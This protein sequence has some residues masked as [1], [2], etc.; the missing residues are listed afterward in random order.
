MQLELTH[1]SDWYKGVAEMVIVLLKLENRAGVAQVQACTHYALG[2][3][4]TRQAI[5][6]A[7]YYKA[8]NRFSV[9]TIIWH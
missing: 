4:W 3:S 8:Y 1:Q 5:N 9:A 6:S 7:C 2:G